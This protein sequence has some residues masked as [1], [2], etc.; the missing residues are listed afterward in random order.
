M[1][2]EETTNA[3]Q[4]A[5]GSQDTTTTTTET[6]A[7][8]TSD[9]LVDGLEKVLNKA[10]SEGAEG[11][12]PPAGATGASGAAVVPGSTGA[13]A[14]AEP[15]PEEKAAAALRAKED[16]ELGSLGVRKNGAAAKRFR[17]L[18]AEA[19]KV[20]DLTKQLE[21]LKP[22][23]E[24]ANRINEI[25][26]ETRATKEQIGETLWYLKATNS[27]DPEQLNKAFDKMVGEVTRLGKILG[28]PINAFDPVADHADLT[29]ELEAAALSPERAREFAATRAREKLEADRRQQ[30][31]EERQ[32]TEARQQIAAEGKAQVDAL[33]AVLRARD[34]THYDAKIAILTQKGVLAGINKRVHPSQWREAVEEAYALL[35]DPVA[36]TPPPIGN[37]PIRPTGAGQGAAMT[38]RPKTAEDAFDFAAKSGNIR[39]AEH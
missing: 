14:A 3:T 28:R 16:Q 15:T 17:D 36:A 2:D 7:A 22:L 8:P 32:Q 1:A 38:A 33:G 24:Q 6:K 4:P 11:S 37:M 18:S 19:R 21:D 13:T 34:P 30:T 10:E 29:N 20:P 9:Q 25:F 35:P 39:M 5:E 31:N 23:A 27:G 12:E 26:A